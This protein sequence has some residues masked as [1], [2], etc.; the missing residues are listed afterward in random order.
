MR[1]HC[2]TNDAVDKNLEERLGQTL[3]KFQCAIHPLDTMA[4]ECEMVVRS[5]EATKNISGM[6]TNG[7]YPFP[8]HSESNTQATVRCT[9]RLFLN[10]SLTAVFTCSP[11]QSQRVFTR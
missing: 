9:A 7:P 2:K 11:S 10:L 5:F 1:D 8:H 3:N 6:K 4:K